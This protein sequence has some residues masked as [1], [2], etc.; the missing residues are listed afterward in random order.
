MINMLPQ[1]SSDAL[2]NHARQ[3][4]AAFVKTATA[5][6]AQPV[7]EY[8]KFLFYRGLGDARLPLHI[9]ESGKGTLTL[10]S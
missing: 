4:D 10:D 2:W 7:Q 3:V 1:T 9:E 8:E 6:G 5:P